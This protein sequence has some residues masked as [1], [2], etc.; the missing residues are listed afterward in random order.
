M[1]RDEIEATTGEPASAAKNSP[2]C[3]W[4]DNIH[5]GSWVLASSAASISADRHRG[6]RRVQSVNEGMSQLPE[7][8][9]HDR[10]RND[11]ARNRRRCR[12]GEVGRYCVGRRGSKIDGE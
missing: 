3:H 5:N 8:A 1:S 4:R 7:N 12:E 10:D 2:S 6:S 11:W 9:A